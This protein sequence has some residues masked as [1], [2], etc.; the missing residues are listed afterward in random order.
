MI[1]II[2]VSCAWLVSRY[3]FTGRK[4]FEWMLILPLSFPGYIMAYAYTG[5]FEYTGPLYSFI[6]NST[7][8]E[9]GSYLIDLMNMQGAVFIFSISL[10][11]YVYLMAR[12]SFLK[13]SMV[14]QEASFL[15]GKSQWQTF[16]KIALPLS[17][18]AIVGGLAL[19]CMEVLND[20]GT[21]KYLGI[22]T[23]TAGIFRAWF[24]MG[25]ST[26]AIYLSAILVLIVFLILFLENSQRGH[27]K[28]SSVITSSNNLMMRKITGWKKAVTFAFLFFVVLIAFVLPFLQL[29][30][31]SWQ[32]LNKVM[33]MSFIH[34][35]FRSF[36]LASVSSILIIAVALTFLYTLRITP[37]RW[38]KILCKWSTLGYAIPGAVIAI[39]VMIPLIR[40]DKWLVQL[41]DMHG[42]LLITGTIAGLIFAYIVRFL[43]VGYHP[44]ESG[45]EKVGIQINEASRMAGAN[46]WKTL[47]KI[48][49]PL[50]K[51]SLLAGFILVFVDLL[52][53]L[54]LTLI[55]RPFNFHTLATKA[56]DLATNEMIAEAALPSLVIIIVGV[57]PII[58]LNKLIRTIQV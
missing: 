48:D 39:G 38:I 54:P 12:T 10:Y 8:Y 20:Y 53:E 47:I 49:L 9:S 22:Q 51:T 50:I 21:V 28:F 24:S 46:S 37:I 35:L 55:L 6:R 43:A 25:D 57:I 3:E 16:K 45:F 7:G 11:P 34:L 27:Q 41:M 58:L 33:D 32:N 2:G 36:L 26:S 30:Y 19:A 31:W 13:Q 5:I 23:F 44:L 14:F 42:T 4:Y 18:P 15:L 17:R 1:G 52:K 29:C 40:L 56:F